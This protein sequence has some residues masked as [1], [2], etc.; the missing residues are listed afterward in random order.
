[1]YCFIMLQNLKVEW[2]EESCKE[3]GCNDFAER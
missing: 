1:M 3:P 2:K